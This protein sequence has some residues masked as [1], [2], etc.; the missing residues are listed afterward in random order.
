MEQPKSM[1]QV[2]EQEQTSLEF[3]S[4]TVQ[5]IPHVVEI[6]QESFTTPWSSQAFMNELTNNHFAQYIILEYDGEVAGYGGMWII[7]DEAHVTNIAI[8]SK[9]RGR[10][11]GE[12]LLIELQNS[13]AFL[14]AVRMTLEVRK[15]NQIAQRLYEKHGFRRVGIRPK[16]YTDNNE[17]ALIMWVN[18]PKYEG[19]SVQSR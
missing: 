11:W 6:E 14:G 1:Q 16:Y 15:S 17:D 10:K 8:K 18:L 13:A 19:E 3:R 7:M 2:Q 9:Y 4:M 12:R 5:D